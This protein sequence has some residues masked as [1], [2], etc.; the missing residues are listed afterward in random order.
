MFKKLLTLV[1]S[2]FLLSNFVCAGADDDPTGWLG[3]SSGGS[4]NFAL[5]LLL[6]QKYYI[7][8]NKTEDITGF[9]YDVDTTGDTPSIKFSSYTQEIGSIDAVSNDRTGYSI[10][11]TSSANGFA[12]KNSDSLPASIPYTLEVPSG[13]N[14]TGPSGVNSS[15]SV[16]ISVGTASNAG[17]LYVNGASL[18]INIPEKTGLIFA[19]NSFS[20]TLTIAVAAE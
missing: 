17:D 3:G 8:V 5:N 16:L 19:S 10:K 20:D 14:Y 13:S 12:L 15:N 9:T 1:M 18:R 7:N 4:V 6:A 2:F 11:T